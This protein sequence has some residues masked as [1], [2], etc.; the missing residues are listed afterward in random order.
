MIQY[1]MIGAWGKTIPDKELLKALSNF[2]VVLDVELRK[3][4]LSNVKISIDDEKILK[5]A[6]KASGKKTKSVAKRKINQM[7]TE[8][9]SE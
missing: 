9:K 7:T 2:G 6:K 4:G 5:N 1:S 3:D 8:K